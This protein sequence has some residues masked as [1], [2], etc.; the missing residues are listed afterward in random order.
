MYYKTVLNEQSTYINTQKQRL[1]LVCCNEAHTP[2]GLNHGWHY[3]ETKDE[4]I[5]AFDLK[6]A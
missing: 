4:A 6:P 1:D 2:L 3:F 5:K